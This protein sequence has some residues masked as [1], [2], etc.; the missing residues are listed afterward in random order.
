M[1]A[2]PYR[3]TA[4]CLLLM[5][6]TCSSLLAVTSGS[7]QSS[8]PTSTGAP[9]L[10]NDWHDV[11]DMFLSVSN[12]G[13]FGN[14]GA[15]GLGWTYPSCEFPA[16]SD[17]DYLFAGGLWVGSIA[18]N[19]DTL[20]SEGLDGW[21][22]FPA[23]SGRHHF[24]YPGDGSSPEDYLVERS[25]RSYDPHYDPNAISEQDFIGTYTD[26]LTNP[27]YVGPNWHPQGIKIVQRSL[28]WSAYDTWD[29][30]IIDFSVLN[31]GQ[32]T[33][34]SVYIGLYLDPDCGPAGPEHEGDKAQDDVCGF[35][36]WREVNDTLW[37]SGTLNS[38]LQD[39]SGTPK[40][41][42]YR[43]YI[44][45]GWVANANYDGHL[46]ATDPLYPI[47]T[48]Q[49]P[50]PSVTGTRVL[51]SPNPNLTA[52]FNWWVPSNV[53]SLSYG[54]ENP[55][56]IY[57]PEGFDVGCPHY[58][59]AS[60]DSTASA[61]YRVLSNGR[62]ANPTE[63]PD[64]WFDPDQLDSTALESF[65]A[66]DGKHA[67][68]Q[69]TRYL[70]SF[71]PIYP[72]FRDPQGVDS[73]QWFFA[74]GD[75]VSLA[76]AYVGGENFHVNKEPGEAG[77][78]TA[79]AVHQGY[80]GYYDFSDLALNCAAAYEIYDTPGIDTDNDGYRGDYVLL[81]NGSSYDT[82]WVSGDGVPEWA[83]GTSE[84]P[85]DKVRPR[86][87]ARLWPGQ[88]NPFDSQTTLHFSNPTPIPRARLTIHNIAGQVVRTL[89]DGPQ[90]AGIHAMVWDGK[91]QHGH[92][93]GSGV[94]LIRLEAAGL[95]QTTR[96]TRIH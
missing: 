2:K 24:F 48:V 87:A 37:P 41:R 25:N 34:R 13:F 66:G 69:D 65:H 91:D 52:S 31:I 10:Q 21:A 79:T 47:Y 73:T 89:C 19:G 60:E 40:Y 44:R 58:G 50:V 61:L 76:F 53:D 72:S 59:N 27:L 6:W 64:G 46:R 1:R 23:G 78:P 32:D 85:G 55:D 62:W 90:E 4:F 45:T 22:G 88:P 30:I 12:W 9:N 14:M 96:L 17:I 83:V 68:W 54:P 84:P 95:A 82:L 80:A 3:L 71:G 7:I 49:W 15:G 28:A 67:T 39:I 51:R 57:G 5:Q 63:Y 29:F 94:Y 16:Y 93:A 74:P 42:D 81:F 75:T 35:R 92:A 77:V 8:H 70:L 86:V 18:A 20:I 33:L 38:Q 36:R 26:T 56:D 11:G 43:E